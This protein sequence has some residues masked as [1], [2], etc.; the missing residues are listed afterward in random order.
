MTDAI[1]FIVLAAVIAVVGVGL[2]LAVAPRL[3]RWDERRSRVEP[4]ETGEREG[5][6][7]RE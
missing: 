7:E 5:E 6:V 4:D 2:G 1:L 3:S